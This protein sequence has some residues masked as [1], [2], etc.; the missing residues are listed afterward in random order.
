MSE[1]CWTQNA[2]ELTFRSE[3]AVMLR[4]LTTNTA[5]S[6]FRKSSLGEI[7]SAMSRKEAHNGVA[8]GNRNSLYLPEKE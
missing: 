3:L 5:Y 2:T 7:P 8:N 6:T 1:Y 4:F